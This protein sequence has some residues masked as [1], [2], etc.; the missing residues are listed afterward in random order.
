MKG[1]VLLVEG[2]FPT[3]HP[4]NRP[5]QREKGSIVSKLPLQV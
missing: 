3:R 5:F 1:A 2:R 4:P